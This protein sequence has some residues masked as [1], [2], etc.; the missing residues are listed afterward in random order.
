MIPDE[1]NLKH[2]ISA[3][4]HMQATFGE[5]QVISIGTM[6]GRIGMLSDPITLHLRRSDGTKLY[7]AVPSKAKD[8]NRKPLIYK[9][10]EVTNNAN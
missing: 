2:F 3:L 7:V 5:C 10:E 6:S 1:I 4:K 9:S 8:A